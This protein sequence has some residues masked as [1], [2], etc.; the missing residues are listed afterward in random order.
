MT[1]LAWWKCASPEARR[2]LEIM[3][4]GWE[5]EPAWPDRFNRPDDKTK[6]SP[7]GAISSILLASCPGASTL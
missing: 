7:H 3:A 2:A 1:R 6:N 5:A 4:H